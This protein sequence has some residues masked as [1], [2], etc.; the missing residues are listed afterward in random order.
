MLA[1]ERS[2]VLKWIYDS[3]RMD[4][5][6]GLF[7]AITI[8]PVLVAFVVILISG[9]GSPTTLADALEWSV[10]QSPRTGLC[11]EVASLSG[12]IIG[13]GGQVPCP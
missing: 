2:F 1:V 9:N 10:I 8:L 11:Y 6:L 3:K 13:V 7:I 5:R 12:E 4:V